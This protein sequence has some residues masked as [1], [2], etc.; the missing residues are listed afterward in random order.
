VSPNKTLYVREDDVPTWE[1]A[2]RYA[3][4]TRQSVSLVVVDALRRFLPSD[5]TVNL[6]PGPGQPVLDEEGTPTLTYGRHPVHGMGWTLW[7]LDATG[8]VDDY[9]IPGDQR[10]ISQ[11]L[12]VTRLRLGGRRGEVEEIRVDVGEP[13]VTRAF[14]GRWLVAPDDRHTRTGEE[15]Y[16]AGAYW[17]IALTKRGRLA[18]YQRHCNDRWPASLNVYDTPEEARADGVPADIAAQAAAELGQEHVIRMDI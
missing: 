7:T 16:D 1:K 12:A 15:G 6:V 3:E 10:E 13:P 2:E 14:E 4:A 11:A 18:V 8:G 9:F 5:I 17:G